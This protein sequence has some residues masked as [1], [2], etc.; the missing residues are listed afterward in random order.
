MILIP[1]GEFLFGIETIAMNMCDRFGP[2]KVDLPAFHIDRHGVTNEQY[3]RFV[4][5]TG[6]ATPEHWTDG[7]VPEGKDTHPVVCVSYHDAQAYCEWAG[8]RLPTEAEWEKAC[9]GTKGQE[10]P[11]GSLIGAARCNSYELG[12]HDTTPVD[13]FPKGQSFYG[14]WDMVGNVWEWTSDFWDEKQELRTVRGG[15]YNL[16]SNNLR[17]ALRYGVHPDRRRRYV[18]F[19]CACDGV[20]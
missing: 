7:K 20:R 8:K 10:F 16:S 9:R 14:V 18:G 2:E 11:W 4:E 3:L 19:R 5:A 12:I 13:H 1:P 6:R 17:C 15:S